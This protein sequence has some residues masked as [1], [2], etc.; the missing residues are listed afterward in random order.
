MK[1]MKKA[2][3]FIEIAPCV[4][5]KGSVHEFSEVI[6]KITKDFG[7][8]NVIDFGC[9]DGKLCKGF[10]RE[11]YLGL[12]S[13]ETILQI[14]RNTFFDYTFALPTNTIYSAD[15]VIA[16]RV[17]SELEEERIH[18]VIR[19][20]RCKWF[21]IAEPLSEISFN[22]RDLEGYKKMMRSH[23]LLLFQHRVTPLEGGNHK[24]ISFLLFKRCGR[25]PNS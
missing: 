16:C 20:M 8:K 4:R 7:V 1:G 19:N 24:E 23:D 3:E 9:G 14:A 10:A 2:A 12:D 15:M 13:D 17:L 22:K 5:E 6:G 11:D 21:L 18:E 25:N